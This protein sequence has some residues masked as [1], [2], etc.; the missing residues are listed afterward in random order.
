MV[1][2]ITVLGEMIMEG[3][4][5]AERFD[6]L[7]VTASHIEMG[8]SHGLVIEHFAEEYREVELVTVELESL[9]RIFHHDGDVI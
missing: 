8:E 1:Q 7:Q 9:V 3:M 6:E 2:R 4:R 5:F